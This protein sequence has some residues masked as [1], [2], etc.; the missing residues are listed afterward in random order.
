MGGYDFLGDWSYEKLL[1]L[2][3]FGRM[4]P[5]KRYFERRGSQHVFGQ[6]DNLNCGYLGPAASTWL[7]ALLME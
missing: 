7:P 3:R 5:N 1:S 6:F 2:R 4:S